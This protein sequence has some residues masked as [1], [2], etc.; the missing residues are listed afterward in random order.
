MIKKSS[1][2]FYYT[3]IGVVFGFIFPIISSIIE[4]MNHKLPFSFSSFFLV[5]GST[6]LLWVIDTAPLFLGVFAFFNGAAQKRLQDHTESLEKLVESRS[7]EIN[8]QKI[9]YEALVQNNPIAVVT[10]DKAH[11]IMTINPAFQE[12]FGFHQDEIIGENLD[13]LIANPSNP[14]ET[15]LLTKQVL[16]GKGIHEFGRRMRKDGQLVD[17]EI[18]GKAILINHDLIGVLGIYRDI[19]NEKRAKESLS[20]S[21]ERFRRMFTDSPVALRMED[22]SQVK[23]WINEKSQDIRAD[24][25]NYLTNHPE[26]VNKLYSLI[27]I[28]DFNTAALQLLNVA[29]KEEL[30][31]RLYSILAE[32]SRNDVIE[33]FCCL[34]EGEVNVERE[35]VYTRLDGKKVYTITKLSIMPGFEESWGRILFSNMDI[36]DRKLVE[37]RIKYVSLHD[38]MT[39]LYNRAFFDE[40]KARLE[41]SRVRPISILV[42]DM[43]NLKKINDHLGHQAGDLALQTIAD[44]IRSSFRSEDVIARIGGDEFSVLLPGVDSEMAQKAKNRILRKITSYNIN[45]NDKFPINLS[46]GWATAEKNESIEETFKLADEIMYQEKQVKKAAELTK[47]S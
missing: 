18:F 34:L 10:L 42:M 23:L 46:I 15:A 26:E 6:P 44:I 17:V 5:Q 29:S 33:I 30:Q 36:T 9:F 11:R 31:G 41:K 13:T 14:E 28:I 8:R 20:A 37:E 7:H 45:K 32:E 47:N 40:E 2:L 25:K 24:F 39:S 3:I 12:M 16:S 27:Q 21:E 4:M 22:L 19:T 43:D 1:P 38:I 35:L